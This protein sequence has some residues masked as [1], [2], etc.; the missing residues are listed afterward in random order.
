MN[1]GVSNDN[2]MYNTHG[3]AAESGNVAPRTVYV[4]EHGTR[5]Q[6]PNSH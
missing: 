3:R 6:G 5:I 4:V 2:S 1:V